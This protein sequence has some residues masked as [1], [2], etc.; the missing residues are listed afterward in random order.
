MYVTGDS[1]RSMLEQYREFARS[2]AVKIGSLAAI[3]SIF[4]IFLFVWMDGEQVL[5]DVPYAI[6]VLRLYC[7]ASALLLFICTFLFSE[8]KRLNFILFY[9]FATSFLF[10]MS[11]RA[12][13]FAGTAHYERT[14]YGVGLTVLI[15]F[16]ILPGGLK[17]L[18]PAYFIS[19][20][21]MAGSLL[22]AG[23]F[24]GNWIQMGNPLALMAACSI[25]SHLQ[26]QESI[27][28]FRASLVVAK[29]AEQIKADSEA[30][31]TI[32]ARLMADM[33]FARRIQY[34][35]IPV[36]SPQLDG[37]RIAGMY[38]PV[39]AIG[40]DYYDYIT[41]REKSMVGVFIGDVCGHG[42]PAAL[43]TCMVKTLVATAGES[44]YSTSEFLSYINEKL[45]EQA[46]G[47][48]VTAFYGIYDTATGLF[49]YSRAGHSFPLLIRRGVVTPLKGKGT[50]LG[51]SLDVDFETRSVRLLPGDRIL[52]YSDGLIEAANA[53][54]EM[55][56]EFSFTE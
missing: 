42:I 48:F 21:L 24:G 27:S 35:L 18:V 43:I 30:M 3:P 56:E 11:A 4:I 1:E 22:A 49:T 7:I 10:V 41:F 12:G 23:K 31:E 6:S 17:S 13:F 16:V 8:K 55:F 38:L 44:K 51:I 39:E 9:L 53:D 26:E 32:H 54:G 40:G 34:T 14:V 28:G 19:L 36:R 29:Q 50:M 2:R 5:N 47:N 25:I 15:T 46:H 52:F 45:V 33:V 20:L 37:V